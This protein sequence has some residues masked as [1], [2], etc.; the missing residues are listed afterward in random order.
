MLPKTKKVGPTPYQFKFFNVNFERSVWCEKSII[1]QSIDRSIDSDSNSLQL[2]T[3]LTASPSL[4]PVLV[5]L[6]D[7][8]TFTSWSTCSIDGEMKRSLNTNGEAGADPLWSDSVKD[9]GESLS[10]GE[11]LAVR[12]HIPSTLVAI[13]SKKCLDCMLDTLTIRFMKK[14]DW[15]G[16]M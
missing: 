12:V 1:I 8:L 7:T 4:F 16:L 11:E 15:K 2:F 3:T 10:N 13:Q 14:N 9:D 6:K 5:I